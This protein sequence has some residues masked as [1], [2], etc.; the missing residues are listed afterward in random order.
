M[1]VEAAPVPSAQRAP[2]STSPQL[3][4]ASPPGGSNLTA[5]SFPP[6]PRTA[7]GDEHL[8]RSRG[9][10]TASPAPSAGE[11]GSSRHDEGHFSFTA[12]PHAQ[13]QHPDHRHGYDDEH[14]P[15]GFTQ[16]R[17]MSLAGVVDFGGEPLARTSSPAM[18][19]GVPAHAQS[20][21]HQLSQLQHHEY[22]ALGRGSGGGGGQAQ[23]ILSSFQFNEYLPEHAHLAPPAHLVQQHLHHHHAGVSSQFAP[24]PPGPAHPFVQY[25]PYTFGTA[26]TPSH[27]LARASYVAGP[28]GPPLEWAKPRATGDEAPNAQHAR[29]FAPPPGSSRAH[30]QQQQQAAHMMYYSPHHPDG[31]MLRT[32]SNQSG[33]SSFS[34]STDLSQHP[35]NGGNASDYEGHHVNPAFVHGG[36]DSG[37]YSSPQMDRSSELARST[38]SSDLRGVSGLRLDGP[39]SSAM[40]R[41]NKAD[42]DRTIRG[43]RLNDMNQSTL[44]AVTGR[45]H[46]DDSR[47]STPSSSGKAARRRV[48]STIFHP[49]PQA[50]LAPGAYSPSGSAIGARRGKPYATTQHTAILPTDDE[51][52]ALPT[53]RSRGRR[54]P[55]TTDLGADEVDPNGEPTQAQIAWA[56]TTK[57]GKVKK[58]F[59]CKVPGC[60]KCFK[61]SEHLKRHVRSIHTNEKPF[62]CQ[63]PTCKRLFSRHDNLNQH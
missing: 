39:S 2:F 57:T 21:H 60:G 34:E 32:T 10:N 5:Y 52:A 58:I 50:M 59:L 35:S 47:A 24:P 56:G 44:R 42:S 8:Q 13:Q 46:A 37:Y 49:P 1:Q 54:P 38:S 22:H 29:A 12:L 17:S 53:K 3:P 18:A 19:H 61:R 7:A 26:T 45:A 4:E 48:A 15:D 63:W 28:P 11:F 25:R 9:N 55:V 14:R 40:S 30:Q 43:L 62:Q 23:R 6:P 41:P 20:P 51:F 33:L 27:P 31:L 36:A 16:P